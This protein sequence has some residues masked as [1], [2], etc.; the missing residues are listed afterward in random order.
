MSDITKEELLP[1]PFCGGQAH[2]V[3]LDRSCYKYAIKCNTCDC[4][5][6]GSAFEN[7]CYNA[8]MW[9]TRQSS[10]EKADNDRCVNYEDK[11]MKCR[12]IIDAAIE[13]GSDSLVIELANGQRLS[14]S[15]YSY[16]TNA[17]GENI[18]IIKAG[19][20]VDSKKFRKNT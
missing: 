7:N 14:T 18:L 8:S 13:S 15:D 3:R 20:E 17:R 10:P 12:D 19:K 2:F 6:G 11:K 1:C 16:G 5:I 4:T 9:N